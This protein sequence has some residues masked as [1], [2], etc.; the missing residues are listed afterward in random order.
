MPQPRP[1]TIDPIADLLQPIESLP[2]VGA[3]SSARLSKLGITTVRSLLWHIPSRYEDFR[4]S[5]AIA[6]IAPGNVY[7]VQG[8]VEAIS[9]RFIFPRRMTITTATIRDDSGSI[10]I[11][12]FNQPYLEES[13]PVGTHLSVSGKVGLDKRGMCFS[14][15]A[16]EKVSPVSGTL[17]HTG[18]LVPIYPQT[19]GVTSKYLRFLIQPVLEHLALRDPL[20]APVLRSYE[21]MDMNTALRDIHY[22]VAV[23]DAVRA[24][25]RLAFD[26]V[27]FVQLKALVDRRTL[28]TLTSLP[29]DAVVADVKSDIARLSFSL[30]KDQRVALLE[31]IKDMERAFPMNRLLQ[32]DV[33]SGKT[34]VAFLAG[35]HV[36]RAGAQTIVLAPTEV[37]AQQHYAT[38]LAVCGPD[39]GVCALLTGSLARL[40]TSD[41]TKKALKEHI[42][43]GQARIVVA[44]HAVLEKNVEFDSLGL[45]VVDEQHRFGIAQRASLVSSRKHRATHTPHL[46]SMTATPIPRTLALT[47]FGD[48]DVSV[49]RQKPKGRKPIETRTV[50]PDQRPS[51]YQYIAREIAQGRQAFV[52]CPLIE[53]AQDEEAESPTTLTELWSEVVTVE[54]EA[55]RLKAD[56]FPGLRIATLHGRMKPQEKRQ[57]M[58]EFRQGWHDIL[59]STSVIEVGVDVPNATIM[60]IE[61]AELFGLAQLHQLRGRVGR[62][63][64]QSVC[65]LASSSGATTQRLRLLCTVDDGFILAE[66]DLKLRGPGEF[67]GLKQSGAS[68]VMLAAL[69]DPKLIAQARKAA[70]A[71]IAKDPTLKKFPEL[72]RQVQQLSLLTHRE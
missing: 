2:F 12:W 43:S 63:E 55:K 19:S 41:T 71:I 7:T 11:V 29:I 24:K 59:V 33:G 70:R 47:L 52:L 37:L 8:V 5:V 67:F 25:R 35:L 27:F 16:Y 60:L 9:N 23:E 22:P 20:P 15:P 26:E 30:T 46:L 51:M 39:K 32:G 34:V 61:G 48:L 36:A 14:S 28:A 53:R 1:T 4:S 56:V 13:L 72:E 3:R 64:H 65:F 18:R 21:L 42:S 44:T 54:E 69:A 50:A 57:I 31:V 17:R 40:G 45:I 66:E 62:G 68:D 6:D 38:L 10:R 58:E 49:L